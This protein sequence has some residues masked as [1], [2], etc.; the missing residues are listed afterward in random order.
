MLCNKNRPSEI[1]SGVKLYSGSV[2]CKDD[3]ER[4]FEKNINI[5]IVLIGQ[6][7]R[8]QQQFKDV[9]L[10]G[11][12]NIISI[13]HKKNVKDII[14]ISSSNVYGGNKHSSN[15]LDPTN[16]KS[17][18]GITKKAVEKLYEKE[19][20]LILRLGNVYGGNARKGLIPNIK[21]A[22]FNNLPLLLPEN[23]V[24]RDFIY[25]DDVVDAIIRVID[26]KK[27]GIYNI[28]T[29][30]NSVYSIVLMFEQF[31]QTEIDKHFILKNMESTIFMNTDKAREEIGFFPER[32]IKEFVRLSKKSPKRISIAK[33][34]L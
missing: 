23:D 15:E 19:N 31:Y 29:E 16:P 17:S 13:M 27:K 25:I 12:K 21:N 6:Q 24:V 20:S 18:Y 7:V 32:K 5:V 11:N 2:L 10:N 9:N 33:R 30:K 14:L 8:N 34:G 4:C 22:I 3:I 28:S 26:E 1:E